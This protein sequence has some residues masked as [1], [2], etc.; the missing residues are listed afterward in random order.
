MQSRTRYVDGTKFETRIG[1]HFVVCDQPVAEGGLDAGVSPPELLLAALGSC[2]GHYALEYL[3][4]RA[5]PLSDLSVTVT[6]ER[7]AESGRLGAFRV[8]VHASGAG[9][10]HRR[11]LLR[12]VKACLI[13]NTLTSIPSIEVEVADEPSARN[14]SG[15]SHFCASTH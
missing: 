14:D 9:E 12:A 6:A 1:A 2:A 8:T 4:A 15:E 13:F 5:L 7:F 10:K 3:R 11:G